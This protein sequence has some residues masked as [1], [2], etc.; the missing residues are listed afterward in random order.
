[1]RK[2]SDGFH[3]IETIFYPL[4]FFDILEIIPATGQS[5]FHYSGLPI[6]GDVNENICFKAYQIL[7]RNFPSLPPIQLHLHKIIPTG[8]G[9]GAGSANGANTL[10]LLNQIFEL[11]I[12]KD[13]LKKY[14]AILGSDCA[15]FIENIPSFATGRGEILEPIDL[16]LSGKYLL[17]IIPSTKIHTAN[18][19]ENIHPKIPKYPL[20]QIINSPLN[21]WKEF[22]E[23]NFEESIFK[24]HPELT[25]IKSQL[26]DAGALYAS[27]SGTGSAIY[28]LFDQQ[29][30]ISFSENR[31]IIKWLTL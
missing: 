26:Y 29:K 10:L 22:L 8:S 4:P 25:S 21:N 11:K 5:S 6:P 19:F 13:N 14:A 20:D 12:S 23:N 28:G 9:L 7:K 1:M 18:A 15:F 27:L 16:N 30:E 2:R 3:D 31:H 17:L 24:S